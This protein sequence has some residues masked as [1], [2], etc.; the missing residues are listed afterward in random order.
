MIQSRVY[1]QQGVIRGLMIVRDAGRT[2][3]DTKLG[4][5]EVPKAIEDSKSAVTLS[6]KVVRPAW[7]PVN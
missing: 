6:D 2:C 7:L 3:C 4:K 1:E 5:T